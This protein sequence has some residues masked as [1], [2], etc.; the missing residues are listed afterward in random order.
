MSTFHAAKRLVVKQ[1]ALTCNLF[2]SLTSACVPVCSSFNLA[3]AVAVMCLCHLAQYNVHYSDGLR[4]G[5]Q[6]IM[7]LWLT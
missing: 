3:V 1:V 5:S 7:H 4:R 6:S 2:G